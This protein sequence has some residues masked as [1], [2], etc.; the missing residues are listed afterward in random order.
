VPQVDRVPAG[1]LEAAALQPVETVA[2]SLAE[3]V[4]VFGR[5]LTRPE[6]PRSSSSEPVAAYPHY[7]S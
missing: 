4:A 5:R 7:R 1:S 3:T 2:A 6:T